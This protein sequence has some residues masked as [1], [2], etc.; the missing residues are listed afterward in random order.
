M[1]ASSAR[2]RYTDG[3]PTKRMA[4]AA[5]LLSEDGR[6]LIVKP[7]Y[8]DYWLLP[9]GVVERD[10]SPR[11]GC[12]RET[13]EELGLELA[14]LRLLCVD[15]TRATAETTESLQFIFWSGYLSAAQLAAIHLQAEELKEW[16]LARQLPACLAALASGSGAIYLEDGEEA[17]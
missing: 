1:S 5:L 13:L 11:R 9:G 14:P 8:R 4:A 17:G 6:L 10:E 7:W 3:L 2:A 12:A 16:R 15:Y